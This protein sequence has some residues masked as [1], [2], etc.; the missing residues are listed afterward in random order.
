[1]TNCDELSE[2]LKNKDKEGLRVE[3]KQSDKLRDQKG[4]G[5]SL[6][7]LANRY[8][9]RL[10]IGIT[11]DGK[12]EGKGIF[13]VD[14]DKGI[15]DNICNNS[16]SPKIDYRTEFLECTEGDVLVVNVNRRKDIPHAYV[17]QTNGEIKNRVYYVRTSHGKRLVTDLQLQM[18]FRNTEEPVINESFSIQIP[19]I[20][21]KI[22]IPYFSK[23][24][25]GHLPFNLFLS[26]FFQNLTDK[27]RA[28]LS[29]DETGKIGELFLELAPFIALSEL[30]NN[31][32]IHWDAKVEKRAG[33]ST[34]S[35]ASNLPKQKIDFSNIYDKNKF[36]IL[37]NLSVEIDKILS[38]PFDMAVPEK[39]DVKVTKS[40]DKRIGNIT[41]LSFKNADL[42][43]IITTFRFSMWT[44]NL[45]YGHPVLSALRDSEISEFQEKFAQVVLDCNF[46]ATFNIF[47]VEIPYFNELFKWAGNMHDI[48]QEKLSWEKFIAGLPDSIIFKIDRNVQDIADELKKDSK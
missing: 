3:L 26:S 35:Q 36:E 25:S 8:G 20:R 38:H 16:C 17:N 40:E 10:I 33:Y 21:K 4:I 5:Y 19:Y 23:L 13:D 28:Y 2:I 29:S 44:V 24:P 22:Q 41:A 45:P 42:F 43:E 46:N 27:D 37:R 31:F 15:I 48:L 12:F 18:M 6:I 11:D 39:V 34:I 1:M 32:S 9:G 47:D 30:T 7:A 14:N